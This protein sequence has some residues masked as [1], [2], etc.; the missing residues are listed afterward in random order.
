MTE[1]RPQFPAGDVPRV[2]V[3]EGRQEPDDAGVALERR[4]L[5]GRGPALVSRVEV[6]AGHAPDA[7][8]ELE[9][10]RFDGT[11]ERRCLP[12]NNKRTRSAQS[13]SIC[14]RSSRMLATSALRETTASSSGVRSNPS[15]AFTS[16][17]PASSRS[18]DACGLLWHAAQCSGGAPFRSGA[19]ML[20]PSARRRMRMASTY[21]S[22]AAQC[23]GVSPLMSG[24]FGFAS[25]MPS[26]SCSASQD[27]CAAAT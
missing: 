4:D 1:S 3:R 9:V 13:I 26:S 23:S 21:P 5:Q 19:L 16:T 22:F 2:D 24:T 20:M 11:D 8:H 15:R 27:S 10:S 7:P 14:G 17:P 18:A 6:D 12:T 25:S